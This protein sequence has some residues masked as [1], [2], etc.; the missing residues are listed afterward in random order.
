M[1]QWQQGQNSGMFFSYYF[2][3][4]GSLALAGEPQTALL[5][6]G[7]EALVEQCSPFFVKRVNLRRAVG[8]LIDWET[9]V[10]PFEDGPFQVADVSKPACAQLFC[11]DA[12]AVAN[13]AVHHDRN[14]FVFMIKPFVEEL[15]AP[16]LRDLKLLARAAVQQQGLDSICIAGPVVQFPGRQLFDFGKFAA[17][18]RFQFW[19]VG[20]GPGTGSASRKNKA[21]RAHSQC[22]K[23]S[24][25]PVAS[26]LGF[27]GVHLNPA[28]ATI[29]CASLRPAAL[30]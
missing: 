9:G 8:A 1:R 28:A 19:P 26:G 13:R 12:G 3:F 10:R 27:A 29:S 20:A 30:V 11:R 2:L 7:M 22:L 6:L 4:Y 15:C 23:N 18:L 21:E 16:Q 17:D 24:R 5:F 25:Q 14:G